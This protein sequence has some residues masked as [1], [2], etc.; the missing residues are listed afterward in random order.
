VAIRVSTASGCGIAA[1]PGCCN[2]STAR[3]NLGLGTIAVQAASNVNITGGSITGITDLAVADGG[4]GASTAAVARTNLGLVPGT[5]VAS[6]SGGKV[7]TFQLP[8]G[9]DLIDALRKRPILLCDFLAAGGNTIDPFS[10]TAIASGSFTTNT[11]T[12][13]TQH[14][15]L[16]RLRS[17]T[18]ANSGVW[19][20][21]GTNQ[22]LLGGGEVYEAIL[23]LD[24]LS[25]STFRVGF[26]NSTS[27]A[28]AADGCYVEVDSSGVATGKTAN[29]ST[30]SSTGT[31]YTL[32]A[33]TFYRIRIVVTSTSSVTFYIYNDSGTLLWSDTLTTNIPSTRTCG[34]L[35]TTTNSGTTAVDLLHLDW[36]AAT[37]ASDRTR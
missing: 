26:H 20:G 34:A 24:T 17:S 10:S 14:P 28:D 37:W 30:R 21:T 27:N 13:N 31:T 4:T 15:G 7:P 6:L 11:A 25:G 1:S 22:V 35:V 8:S 32:S 19:L 33:A 18:N 16:A 36:M 12:V 2:A 3:T 23:Y 29:N 9:S 5:D